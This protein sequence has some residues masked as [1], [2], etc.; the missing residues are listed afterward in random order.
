M[1]K[2]TKSQADCL[3]VLRSPGFSPAKIAVAARLDL[4]K[5]KAALRKLAEL[6][7]AEQGSSTGWLV[8]ADGET[9]G[10]ET[11]PDQRARRGRPPAPGAQLVLDLLDRPIG[12]PA[13]PGP[14]AQRLLDLLDRPMHGPELARKSG[15]SRQRVLQ[16]LLALHAQGRISFGDPDHPSW[17]VKRADDDTPILSREEQR[18]LSALPR[19]RATDATGLGVVARLSDDEVE[20]VADKL[21]VAGLAEACDGLAGRRAFRITAIGLDHPQYFAPARQAPPPRLPVHSDR[22]RTVLQTISDAG[23]LRILDVKRVTKIQQQ[24]INAL[25][26]YLKRRRLVAKTGD[27]LD[28]PYSLTEQG[29]AVLAE[30]TLRRAA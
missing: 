20:P 26:Q 1:L 29:R 4:K 16:L 30:M 21:V 25:M 12:G 7:L 2:L 3:R 28:A 17:L 15:L 27:R 6:G 8:T 14:G 11:V 5:T 9:C 13:Q 22:V 10:F 18:V 19:Q 23:A 24:S